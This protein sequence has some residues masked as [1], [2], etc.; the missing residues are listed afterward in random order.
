MEI[1]CCY[2]NIKL[3]LLLLLLLLYNIFA[4]NLE[5]QNWNAVIHL[6]SVIKMEKKINLDNINQ[7]CTLEMDIKQGTKSLENQ[8]SR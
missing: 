5:R 3:Y 2:I 8:L 6:I 7:Q 1:F 4:N